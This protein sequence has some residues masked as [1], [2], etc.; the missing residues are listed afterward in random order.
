[1]F[2]KGVAFVL[3]E[4]TSF[5]WWLLENKGG[6]LVK[7]GGSF[8]KG[9]FLKGGGRLLLS[10]FL[11]GGSGSLIKGGSFLRGGAPLRGGLLV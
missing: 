5:G 11:C 6:V 2:R 7:S 10:R 3:K 9:A 1:M 8:S 4:E